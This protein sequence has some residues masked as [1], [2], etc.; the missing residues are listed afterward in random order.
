M[1]VALH[2]ISHIACP[3][4]NHT[5]LFKQIFRFICEEAIAYGIYKKIDFDVSPKEYC[6][7]TINDTVV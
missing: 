6:G 7:M 3:E 4:Y 2:E 1:Y 5:T